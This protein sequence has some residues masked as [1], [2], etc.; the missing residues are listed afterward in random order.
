MIEIKKLTPDLI[1]TFISFFEELQFKYKVK[2]GDCY[3]YY[4]HS[5]IPAN[6]WQQQKLEDR[7][8]GS[9]QAIKDGILTGFLAFKDNECVGF[10]NINDAKKYIK[11]DNKLNSYIQGKKVALSI[12]FLVSPEYREHGIARKILDYAIDF[13]RSEGYDGMISLPVDQDIE[14]VYHYLGTMNMYAERGY[15]TIDQID[16]QKIMYKQL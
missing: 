3:C 15:E 12:C 7:K 11:L 4:Y 6:Q 9:I 13:Y 16:R 8:N 1:E 10:A 5:N 2:E 14:K